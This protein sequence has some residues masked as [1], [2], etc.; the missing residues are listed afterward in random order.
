MRFAGGPTLALSVRELITT[1][2]RQPGD[3]QYPAN[4]SERERCVRVKAFR[5]SRG[6]G[7]NLPTG[8]PAWAAA[9]GGTLKRDLLLVSPIHVPSQAR[10]EAVYEVHHLWEAIDRDALLARIAPR[11]EILVTTGG[12]GASRALME[13][14]RCCV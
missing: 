3:V 13:A 5:S 4:P 9:T 6:C 1:L 7:L 10:L 11:V 12:A 14:C 8:R 2:R